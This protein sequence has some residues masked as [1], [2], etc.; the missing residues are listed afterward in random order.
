MNSAIT[1]NMDHDSGLGSLAR[2]FSNYI[3]MNEY[4]HITENIKNVG[5]DQ[6]LI[7]VQLLVIP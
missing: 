7:L 5:A 2:W 3:Y 1:Q 6:L 4:V